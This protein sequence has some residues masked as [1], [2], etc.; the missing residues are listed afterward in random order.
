MIYNNCLIS[1][2]V[3]TPGIPSLRKTSEDLSM[4]FS[5]LFQREW[6]TP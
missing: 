5:V 6:E 1:L 2:S 4:T 3:G